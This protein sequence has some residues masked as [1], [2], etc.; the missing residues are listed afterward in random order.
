MVTGLKLRN[1]KLDK[2]Q[3]AGMKEPELSYHR[4]AEPLPY[5]L[6][7]EALLDKNINFRFFEGS[8]DMFSTP[9]KIGFCDIAIPGVN[10][11]KEEHLGLFKD[12]VVELW[13]D[14]DSAGQ[15]GCQQLKEKLEKAGV[16]VLIKN[17]DITLGSDVNEVLKN[18]NIEKI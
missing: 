13:F 4:I 1:T 16:T 5:S 15:K 6:T 2:W 10:G 9:F 12:R 14:Q 11:I 17:W 18:G 8:V 7:R 3:D